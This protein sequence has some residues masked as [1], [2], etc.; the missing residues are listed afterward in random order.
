MSLLAHVSVY[1]LK[2][3]N[4]VTLPPHLSLPLQRLQLSLVRL[5]PQRL[6]DFGHD[7]DL[8]AAVADGR[9]VL[10]L[11][12]ITHEPQHR[13]PHRQSSLSRHAGHK[14]TKGSSGEIIVPLLVRSWL[15]TGLSSR[16]SHQHHGAQTVTAAHSQN[17]SAL[18]T[19]KLS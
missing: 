14:E 4:S 13:D 18:I 11:R 6:V 19:S 15:V 3:L 8:L 12:E 5:F 10:W 9:V 7:W 1:S 17:L 16:T 2:P